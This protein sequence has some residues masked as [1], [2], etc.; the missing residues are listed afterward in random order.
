MGSPLLS[1]RN[2]GP[3]YHSGRGTS[4]T[5]RPTDLF[6]FKEAPGASENVL[7]QDH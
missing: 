1:Q 2:S 6:Q 5:H 4:L 7:D 3:G